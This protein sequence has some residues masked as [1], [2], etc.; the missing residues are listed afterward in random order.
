MQEANEKRLQRLMHPAVTLGDMAVILLRGN[1]FE[2]MLEVL[3]Y[4]TKMQD[5]VVG[6]IKP[7]RLQEI[8]Q[9]CIARGHTEGAMV[10][11]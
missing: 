6:A 10:N 2:K 9:T 8:F 1:Q 11:F 4:L 7:E 5:S 3:E